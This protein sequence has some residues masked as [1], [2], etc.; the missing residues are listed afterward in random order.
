MKSSLKKLLIASGICLLSFG[1]VAPATLG[2][3]I[4]GGGALY[5]G[6]LASG[7]NPTATT[8]VLTT[9]V[10]NDG[11]ALTGWNCWTVDANSPSIEYICGNASGT[12][13]TN[14]MRG[15]MYTNPNASS[16]ALAFQHNRGASVQITDYPDLQILA[17]QL[18]GLDAIN[19]TL[20]YSSHPTSTASSTIEDKNYID[21]QTSVGVPA[22]TSTPGT[23][24]IATSQQIASGTTTSTYNSN[25]YNLALPVGQGTKISGTPPTVNSYTASGT[26]T[27]SWTASYTGSNGSFTLPSV[28]STTTNG[29][30]V[31]S[32]VSMVVT[33]KAANG[34]NSYSGGYT[35]GLGA[36]ITATFPAGYATP[37]TTFY[38]SVPSAGTNGT[39]GGSASG[40][41][42]DGGS[43]LGSVSSHGDGG[44]GGGAW[45]NSSNSSST[46]LLAAG[47]GSGAN[48]YQTSGYGPGGGGGAGRSL[49]GNMGGGNVA[50]QN[51]PAGTTYA[52]GAFTNISTSTNSGNGSLSVTW[53]YNYQTENVSTTVT[54]FN[55][56]GKITVGA[57]QQWITPT[58]TTLNF[59]ASPAWT[60]VPFCTANIAT[61]TLSS[62]TVS[63]LNTTTSSVQFGFG[64]ATFANES[65]NYN[66]VGN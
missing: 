35:G 41:Y 52:N 27:L 43:T 65:L 56:G 36:T 64:G 5:D 26:D 45:I 25:T 42:Q 50:P 57:A 28:G 17:R 15:V 32:S 22:T 14:L 31:S 11:T 62:T 3:V 34:G 38:Y 44:G 12:S 66:C 47:G 20:F 21:T 53:T 59:S 8:M 54:G 33:I 46:S 63:I 19:G 61:S 51:G 16:S 55:G 2:A 58:S 10:F 48:D 29:D 9:G 39:N 18:G 30:V 23:V 24:M 1:I 4:P 37:G 13:V 60:I 7:I 40:G 49:G 6:F